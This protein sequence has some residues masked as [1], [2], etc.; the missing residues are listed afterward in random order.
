MGLMVVGNGLSGWAQV[1]GDGR[2]DVTLRAEAKLVTVP[3]AVRD[4]KG[5]LVKTLGKGDFALSVDGQVRQIRYFDKDDNLPLT[6]GL[7]VDTSMSQRAVLDEERE[8]STAFLETML[9][10]HGGEVKDKAFVIEFAHE[11]NLLQ[12][13][14]DGKGK[15][16]AALKQIDADGRDQQTTPD[17]GGWGD[18]RGHGGRGGHGGTVL[19]DAVYLSGN[20]LMAKQQGRKA[21]VILSDG[22]DRGSQETLAKAIEAAQRVDTVIYAIYFKG[23]DFGGG[24]GYGGGHG[25]RRDGGGGESRV[26][27]KK[28]LARMCEETGGRLFEVKGKET[29]AAIYGEIGEELRSQYRLGFS[30]TAADAEDGYHRI[31]VTVPAEAKDR[32]QARDGYYLGK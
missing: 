22:D 9:T 21:L 29:V 24:G 23:Q 32:V 2:P 28:V 3:V 4:K 1:A 16:Q 27:G 26:D 30:P 7:L 11:A 31:E 14:T 5:V 8:A 17:E 18:R 6:L 10:T 20:E 12:D 13:V 15:L 19:Y 25:G